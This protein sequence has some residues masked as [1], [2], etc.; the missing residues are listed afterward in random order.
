MKR[1]AFIVGLVLVM[2][3]SSFSFG[4]ALGTTTR[5]AIPSAVQQIISVDYRALRNSPTAIEL[6]NKV[7]PDNLKEFETALRGIGLNPDTEVEQLTFASFRVKSGLKIIGVATGQFPSKKFVQK[8]KLKKI[9][10]NKYRR[11]IVYPM[12]GGIQM[13]FL[14]DYTMLFGDQSAVRAALDA[15]DGE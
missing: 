10:G 5:T 9:T 13:S 15:R 8:L 6:K 12:N 3:G 2:L 4:A 1:F 14:D 7:L 11:A